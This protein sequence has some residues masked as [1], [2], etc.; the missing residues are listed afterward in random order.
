MGNKNI[1]VWSNIK[2]PTLRRNPTKLIFTT[3]SHF[4]VIMHIYMEKI[5]LFSFFFL[6][7]SLSLYAKLLWVLKVFQKLWNYNQHLRNWI[8][9]GP[10]GFS[11]W[12][13]NLIIVIILLKECCLF[14]YYMIHK[15]SSVFG[16]CADWYQEDICR[17]YILWDN[18]VQI[19]WE[20]WLYW[21]WS[22]TLSYAFLQKFS[23]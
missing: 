20:H 3:P 11:I 23:Y 4:E 10:K 17:V 15:S 2:G 5:F 13:W 14:V 9:C 16:H 22:G 18:A 6:S 7:L 12:K 8:Y 21:L 1:V 19:E